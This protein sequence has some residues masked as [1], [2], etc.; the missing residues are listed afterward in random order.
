MSSSDR[1]RD[2]LAEQ[3]R[4]GRRI[5]EFRRRAGLS[6][7]TLAKEAGMSLDGVSRILLGRRAPHLESL[8]ALSR[9]LKVD[10][11]ELL[12]DPTLTPGGYRESVERVATFLENQPEPVVLALEQCAHAVAHLGTGR[13]AQAS[14]RASS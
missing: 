8:L 12:A 14:P 11:R 2:V 7:A 13:A 1:G 10:Y 9:A 4:I 6:Q 3:A 5:E